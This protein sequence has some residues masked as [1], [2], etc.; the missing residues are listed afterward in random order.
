VRVP[1]ARSLKRNAVCA[2]PRCQQGPPAA[3]GS[4]LGPRRGGTACLD[5]ARSRRYPWGLVA[6]RDTC[7][8]SIPPRGMRASRARNGAT[9]HQASGVPHA[10]S[11]PVVGSALLGVLAGAACSRYH[12]PIRPTPC[13]CCPTASGSAPARSPLSATYLGDRRFDA[14]DLGTAAIRARQDGDRKAL[15]PVAIDRAALG[16]DDRLDYDTFRWLLERQ[17]GGRSSAVPDPAHPPGVSNP[18]RG[19]RAAAL[20]WG[21]GTT[22]TG[23]RACASSAATS[24]RPSPDARGV[25]RACCRRA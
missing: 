6:A 13:T 16:P 14:M 20:Y 2:R 24:T 22:R 4:A 3:P 8:N 18:A 7:P 5:G 12:G 1:Q 9:I 25:R 11:N 21:S 19:H 23:W 10:N 17:V 15:A